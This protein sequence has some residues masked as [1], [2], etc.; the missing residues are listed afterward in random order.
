MS[1]GSKD[2]CTGDGGHHE[3][4]SGY[5]LVMISAIW[6]SIQGRIAWLVMWGDVR[7]AGGMA[8]RQPKGDRDGL[9]QAELRESDR[10]LPRR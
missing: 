8:G 4:E 10:L 7:V 1:M 6:S 9:M 5:G 3:A 2:V